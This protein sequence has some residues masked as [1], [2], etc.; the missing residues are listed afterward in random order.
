MDKAIKARAAGHHVICPVCD[1]AGRSGRLRSACRLCWMTGLLPWWRY[2]HLMEDYRRNHAGCGPDP[3]G[4]GA[5]TLG[6][7]A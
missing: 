3:D 4:T 7:A 2:E 5:G 6:L 1:G